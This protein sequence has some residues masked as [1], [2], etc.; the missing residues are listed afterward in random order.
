MTQPRPRPRDPRPL[1]RPANSL[2]AALVWGV[3]GAAFTVAVSG[4]ARAVG[5]P[6]EVIPDGGTGTME[7]GPL[8]LVAATMVAALLAGIGAAVLG[9]IV[10]RPVPWLI[11]AGAAFTL[12]SLSAPLGQPPEIP[13]A[14]RAVL[15]ICQVVTG[16]L[17][18]Y[19]LVRGSIGDDRVAG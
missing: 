10:R 9:R 14:T 17:V 16:I 1:R 4:L 5:V 8:V 19:G 15:A 11:I 6:M 12:G 7:L 3:G 18:T 2:R 13:P